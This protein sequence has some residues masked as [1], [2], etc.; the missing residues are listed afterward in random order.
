MKQ[1][2]ERKM[3]F[4]VLEISLEGTSFLEEQGLD[5][6]ETLRK[7]LA[8][9]GSDVLAFKNFNLS[10]VLIS[11]MPEKLQ[12]SAEA[13]IAAFSDSEEFKRSATLILASNTAAFSDLE[14]L[15]RFLQFVHIK[16]KD[17]KELLI[18]A[19]EE[20]IAQYKRKFVIEQ[21]ITE[22]LEE[23]RVEIFLQP[24]Y[25][26]QEKRFASAEALVRIRK[27]DGDLLPPGLFIP[28]AEA[29]GQI[30]ELGERVF[31][32]VCQLLQQVD[33]ASLGVRY[34]EINLFVVQC[35]KTNL[36]DRLISIMNQYQ[37]SPE[38][39]NLEITETASIGAQKT[40]LK[41]MKTLIEYG[42]TFSLDDFGKGESN[43][44]YVVEMPVSIV[45][46]DYD[47][48]KSFFQSVKAKQVVR[49]VLSMAHSLN[50]KVVA[51]GIETEEEASYM[52]QEGVDYIQGFH[53][54]KPLPLQEYVE[55]I[56]A[57][58][59]NV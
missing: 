15:M 37:V 48:S 11:G 19:D 20:M 30:L 13:V 52:E 10:L 57:H 3:D 33:I 34:I 55:F 21:Q 23:D 42:L 41:N 53:Y 47:M 45:K 28:V 14:E 9:A 18:Y 26:S 7:I 46:L 24:I 36:S 44:M 1:L 58:A 25:S 39:I 59:Q 54:S 43:L 4:G 17:E 50:L 16:D 49:A 38:M 31:E 27:P 2:Y 8:A 56:M 12:S 32:K 22:A 40:L 6:N 51:E 35:E 29:T 5:A